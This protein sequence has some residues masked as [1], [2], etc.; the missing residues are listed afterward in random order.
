MAEKEPPSCVIIARA[1]YHTDPIV[2]RGIDAFHTTYAAVSKEEQ[3]SMLWQASKSAVAK[4]AP[5]ILSYDFAHPDDD[6]CAPHQEYQDFMFDKLAAK[7]GVERE[8]RDQVKLPT[9][10]PR[11]GFEPT[12]N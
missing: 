7:L 6:I 3:F 5:S 10:L 12:K 9:G 2:T 8:Q 11:P 4:I 1:G